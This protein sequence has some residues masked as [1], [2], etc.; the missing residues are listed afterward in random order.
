MAG[1]SDEVHEMDADE[2]AGKLAE[3]IA[4]ALF[5]LVALDQWDSAPAEYQIRFGHVLRTRL[6]AAHV[7]IMERGKTLRWN[8]DQCGCV[9][10]TDFLGANISESEKNP[11]GDDAWASCPWCGRGCD[12]YH[13]V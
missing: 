7:Q 2:F 10:N 9:F 6:L 3:A 5:S 12:T 8:C 11:P 13:I 4:E 1:L